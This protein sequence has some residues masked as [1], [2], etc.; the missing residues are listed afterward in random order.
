MKAAKPKI[1]VSPPE[2]VEDFV[3]LALEKGG[4]DEVVKILRDWRGSQAIRKCL[5]GPEK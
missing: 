1:L 5:N 4:L 3:V 2:T